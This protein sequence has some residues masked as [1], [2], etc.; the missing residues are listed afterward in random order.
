MKTLLTTIATTI[1]IA[2][3]CQQVTTKDYEVRYYE[4]HNPKWMQTTPGTQI[5]KASINTITGSIVSLMG[6]YLYTKSIGDPDIPEVMP[7]IGIAGICI[8]GLLALKGQFHIY[9]A[10]ILLDSRGIGLTIP[11]GK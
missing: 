1:C 8:G 11:I 5:R 4:H 7:K 6:T 10:G 2:T 3:L 9:R